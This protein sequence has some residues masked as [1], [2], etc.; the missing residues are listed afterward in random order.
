MQEDPVLALEEEVDTEIRHNARRRPGLSRESTAT[1]AT[2]KSAAVAYTEVDEE[3]PLLINDRNPLQ[4]QAVEMP[5]YR[6]ASV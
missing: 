6:K 4:D 1:F 5:W 2:K 3:S